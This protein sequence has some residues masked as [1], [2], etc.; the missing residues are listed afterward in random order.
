MIEPAGHGS[1][2]RGPWCHVEFLFPADEEGFLTGVMG[3]DAS[4]AVQL[5]LVGFLSGLVVEMRGIRRRGWG[6]FWRAGEALL[7]LDRLSHGSV[8]SF[9]CGRGILCLSGYCEARCCSR[10]QLGAY[11]LGQHGRCNSHAAFSPPRSHEPCRTHHTSRELRRRTHGRRRRTQHLG[12]GP[13]SP[14]L[15]EYPPSVQNRQVTRTPS[16]PIIS[17]LPAEAPRRKSYIGRM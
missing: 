7:F 9:A 11:L 6:R 16:L 17:S 1:T 14:A 4:S 13:R 12:F 10:G 2:G 8:D 15:C 5:C 3:A